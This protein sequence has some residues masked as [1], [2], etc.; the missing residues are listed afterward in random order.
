MKTNS[1]KRDEIN[2]SWYLVDADGSTL[3][4]LSSKIAHILRGKNK[5]NFTPSIDMSDFIIV[6]NADKIKLTGDKENNKKYW[7]H[8]GFPGGGSI[9][10]YKLL[11]E[12]DAEKIIQ[13]SV[14]GM[15]PHNK[16]GNKLIK[17]LKVYKGKNHPHA[18]QN[19][20]SMEF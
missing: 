7:K 19:P 6:I 2:R 18:S 1:I 10:S 3:G 14:K 9:T 8:T 13:K 20:I 17:H 12:K 11:K 5:V 4:R 15:L 16:L